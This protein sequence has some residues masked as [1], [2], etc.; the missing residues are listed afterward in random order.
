MRVIKLAWQ[1]FGEGGS[2]TVWK[3][4]SVGLHP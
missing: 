2:G 4:E 3:R 1:E